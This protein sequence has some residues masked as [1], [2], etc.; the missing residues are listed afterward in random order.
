MDGVGGYN[1]AVKAVI[2]ELQV[3]GE[4]LFLSCRYPFI[5]SLEVFYQSYKL[6]ISHYKDVLK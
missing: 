3:S 2:V 6:M 1:L 5:P 4:Q